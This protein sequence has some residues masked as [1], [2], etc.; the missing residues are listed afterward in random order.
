MPNNFPPWHYGAPAN[1]ALDQGWL[2]SRIWPN[3]LRA[4]LRHLAGRND[5]PQ[6]QRSTTAERFNRRPESGERAGYDAGKKRKGSKVHIAVDTLGHLLAL[7]V[8]PAN[9]QDRERKLPN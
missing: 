8:T 2:L 1:D 7:T 5:Q 6:P 9:E 4:I 3:D